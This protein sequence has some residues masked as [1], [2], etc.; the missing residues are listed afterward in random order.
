MYN[1]VKIH[2]QQSNV[3]RAEECIRVEGYGELSKDEK[4]IV[5]RIIEIMKGEDD[6]EVFTFKR[7]EKCK[8]NEITA[9]VNKLVARIQTDN[10]TDTNKL[11][12]AVRSVVAEKI[13]LKEVIEQTKQKE[14]W[15]KRRLDM[16]LNR[17]RKDINI[18][19]R[20]KRG[21]IRK[22][23]KYKRLEEKYKIRTK[24][25]PTV[26]EELKQRVLAKIAKV[27]RYEQRV[28]QYRQNRMFQS[29]QK[30]FYVEIY[31]G[32]ESK[33]DKVIPDADESKKV[34]ERNMGQWN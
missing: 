33:V 11:L 21:E 5:D 17:L 29:D 12:K 10:I 18:L 7:V 6:Y 34:L 14:P 13:R 32:Q 16:D 26:T 8:I 15:W 23:G 31:N 4:E 19:E 28:K 20:K 3:R 25:L 2:R 1:I 22:E 30:R 27:K 9:K 24:V